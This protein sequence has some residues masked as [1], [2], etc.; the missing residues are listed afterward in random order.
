MAKKSGF[1]SVGDRQV[2]S[3]LKNNPDCK[4]YKDVLDKRAIKKGFDNHSDRQKIW[5]IKKM[6]F[7]GRE[8]YNEY[9]I[10]LEA[11]K[12]AIILIEQE[13]KQENKDK[14]ELMRF[15]YNLKKGKYLIKS[16]G[17]PRGS[18]SYNKEELEFLRIRL[19]NGIKY[20]TIL[21]EFSK[22]FNR[23]FPKNSRGLYNLMH[24]LNWIT[25]EKRNFHNEDRDC[26]RCK[27]KKAM[28]KKGIENNLQRYKCKFCK[29]NERKIINKY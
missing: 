1:K 14:R 20:K 4:T 25:P 26:S 2:F 23:R 11:K 18:I 28:I 7:K 9:L 19:L 16:M 5:R 3:A 12:K 15:Y 8:E 13:L 10:F 22:K 24:R 17:R 21:E 27:K 29:N 6:G